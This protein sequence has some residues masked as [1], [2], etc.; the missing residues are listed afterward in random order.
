MPRP[1]REL[2]LGGGT[3]TEQTARM[4]GRARAAARRGARGR[5]ARLRR[6]ELDARRRARGG[7]GAASRSRTSRRGCARSTAAMPEELNRVLTDHLSDLLLVPARDG[8]GEPARA[9]A[10]PARVRLVGDVMVDVAHLVQPR[11]REDPRRCARRASSPA[12]YVLA[13]AHRA[14]NVDDPRAA[15][16][17]VDAA[18][19]GA[20]RT[21]SC[22]CIRAPARGWRRRGCSTRSRRRTSRSRRRS[23]YLAFTSLLVHAPRG[24]HR[25]RRRA[26]GGVPRRRAVRDAARHDGV[27]RDGRRRGGTCS[28]TSTPR[29]RWR[30]WRRGRRPP[31]PSSTATAARASA[32]WPSSRRWRPDRRRSR[33][34]GDREARRVE[35]AAPVDDRARARDVG[36][37]SSRYS[38]WSACRIAPAT[39]SPSHGVNPSAASSASS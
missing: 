31:G 35:H 10:S 24:A 36:R 28:S 9:R 14:G 37:R 22:R 16:V 29:R 2:G 11:A 21:S 26:E 8:R 32:S 5:G 1:E 17:L 7:A 3:N 33:S 12:S 23:G 15:R 4:L 20:V 39:G 6:H 38:A 30:R 18:A 34:T 25:L 27:G 19:R 13:T